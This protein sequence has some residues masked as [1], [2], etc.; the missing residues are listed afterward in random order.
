[1]LKK[2]IVEEKSGKK[3]KP[4]KTRGIIIILVNLELKVKRIKKCIF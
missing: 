2:R 4:L 1:M 3:K